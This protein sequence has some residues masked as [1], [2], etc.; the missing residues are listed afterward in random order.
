[1][2]SDRLAC[3]QCGMERPGAPVR[4]PGPGHWRCPR[5][6]VRNGRLQDARACGAD[7]RAI[8]D[9][10]RSVDGTALLFQWMEVARRSSL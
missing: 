3:Q 4:E 5:C 8:G 10:L 6:V 7:R 1:M 2:R 9:L